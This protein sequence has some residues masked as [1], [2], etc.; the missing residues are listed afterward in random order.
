MRLKNHSEWID[1]HTTDEFAFKNNVVTE[2]HSF[3]TKQKALDWEGISAL[4]V[5]SLVHLAYDF[6]VALFAL[7]SPYLVMVGIFRTDLY[8]IIPYSRLLPLFT[9]LVTSLLFYG[10]MV[11]RKR[12]QRL[13]R[14]RIRMAVTILASLLGLWFYSMLFLRPGSDLGEQD[15]SYSLLEQREAILI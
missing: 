13:G 6:F 11:L 3:T 7:T 4:K 2:F 1:A 10:G 15:D 12:S 8:E 5:H 9:P 14:P